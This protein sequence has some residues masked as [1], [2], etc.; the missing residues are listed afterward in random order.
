MNTLRI[1]LVQSALADGDTKENLAKALNVITASRGKADLVV[2][3]ETY[4]CGFPTAENIQQLSE[5]IDGPSISAVRAAAK[6]ASI[7][8]A[9]G[10]AEAEHGRYFNT[11]VLIDAHGE[12]R[13]RYRKSCLYDSDRGVFEPG[14]EFPVCEWHGIRIGL[15]ICFDIEFPGPAYNIARNGADVIVLLDGLM[16]PYGHMH[17]NAIPIRALDNQVYIAMANRVGSGEQYRFSG[18]SHVADPFGKTLALASAEDEAV[19]DI[20]LDLGEIERAR[21]AA[22]AMPDIAWTN[23]GS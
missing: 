8:V 15:L 4:T 5:P 19:L 18:E 1:R 6:R 20:T 2:F 17:R 21:A 3:S 16:H 10:F 12:V 22:R 14:A 7:S 23:S 11:A 13:L 9:I